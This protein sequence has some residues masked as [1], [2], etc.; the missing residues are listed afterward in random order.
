MIGA[1]GD[2]LKHDDILGE[3]VPPQLE[4][5]LQVMVMQLV[6]NLPPDHHP[7]RP[8]FPGSQP[9]HH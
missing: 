6:L 5:Q 4:E 9:V 3:A 1:E 7:D 2:E 8:V